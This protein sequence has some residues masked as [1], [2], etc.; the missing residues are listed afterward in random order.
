MMEVASVQ[1]PLSSLVAVVQGVADLSESGY[2]VQVCLF[3][4]S[5]LHKFRPNQP[6]LTI[7]IAT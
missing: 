2:L 7:D 1:H 3:R 4:A 5:T 6:G